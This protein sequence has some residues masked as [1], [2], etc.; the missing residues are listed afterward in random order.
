MA[1]IEL[2]QVTI[3]YDQ[4]AFIDSM[5][6]KIKKGKITTIVGPNGSGKSTLLKAISRIIKPK[7][8]SILLDSHSIHHMPTKQLAKQLAI[9]PQ[10]NQVPDKLT[11][12]DLVWLGRYPHQGMFKKKSR[13]DDIIVRQAMV[14][15]DV[16]SMAHLALD[17][18][19]GGQQQRAWIAMAL[20]QNTPYLLL[21]EPT[22]F[23]DMSHQLETLELLK[24]LN[25]HCQKT[26][27]MVLHD[28]NLAARYSD[29]LILLDKGRVI[30]Q[31]P[32]AQVLTEDT[33]H[34]IF[35]IKVNIL[36]DSETGAPYFIPYC[37]DCSSSC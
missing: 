27:I 11:V 12:S 30:E 25:Q 14:H 32:P 21:D 10:Q 24:K 13:D 7:E 20:A 4:T 2:K 33:L 36:V 16:A 29:E 26:I 19:S 28:V 9:L 3:N 35:K 6:L 18:L 23:L 34:K 37:C 1:E 8:G 22:T 31:G 17:E 15:T 5:G